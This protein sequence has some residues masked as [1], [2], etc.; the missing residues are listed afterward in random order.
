M[1]KYYPVMMNIEGAPALVVGGG[2]IA[3]RKAEGLLEYGARVTIV[4]REA[5]P[6]VRRLYDE[7]RVQLHER[8]FVDADLNE[9]VIVFAATN[10]R[11]LHEHI[12]TECDRRRILCNVV[13]VPDLC[14]F[15]VPSIIRRGELM[16]TI[17]TDGL[18]PAYSKFQRKRMEQCC[19]PEGAQAMLH[20]IAAARN[21]LKGPLGKG[22]GDEKKFE[23]LRQLVE[24]GLEDR[25]ALEGEAAAS[26]Y[27]VNRIHELAAK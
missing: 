3:S 10:D 21:E 23:L 8:P 6:D 9:P 12:K 15:I 25:L 5:S 26:A 22:L 4:A 19:F 1:P 18:C 2:A 17:S 16:I 11:A 14:G 20:V 7:E 27:A 13:D 24:E